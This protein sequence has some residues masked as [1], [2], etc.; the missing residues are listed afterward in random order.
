[1]RV[2]VQKGLKRSAVQLTSMMD[3]LFVIIFAFMLKTSGEVRTL[4]EKTSAGLLNELRA[5]QAKI[6][7]YED[8][9]LSLERDSQDVSTLETRILELET[10]VKAL[11]NASVRDKQ[12]LRELEVERSEVVET[13]AEI[14]TRKAE[15]E[16][17]RSRIAA[18]QME[19]SNLKVSAESPPGQ[20]PGSAGQ[21]FSSPVPG[22]WEMIPESL[23]QYHQAE[24]MKYFLDI[25]RVGPGP[26]GTTRYFVTEI[27]YSRYGKIYEESDGYFNAK[28][29]EFDTKTRG[30]T[31]TEG[32][33]LISRFDKLGLGYVLLLNAGAKAR[34]WATFPADDLWYVAAD[35]KSMKSG[36]GQHPDP[37]RQLTGGRSRARLL[38]PD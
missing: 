20:A 13:A 12:R 37:D 35:G 31:R 5:A 18:L 16:R 7:N 17:A 15:L 26:A 9:L 36:S 6:E 2:G 22:R 24:G 38:S 32:D 23:D 27:R 29:G 19:L 8:T 30:L 34:G 10:L 33:Y 25:K 4:A 14:K 1:M 3:L 21:E 11:R 28:T